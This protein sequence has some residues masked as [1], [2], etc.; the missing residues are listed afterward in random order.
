MHGTAQVITVKPGMPIMGTTV[1]DGGHVN[2]A[3]YQNAAQG[4]NTP[5]WITRASP[6]MRSPQCTMK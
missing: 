5:L 6:F 2:V 3:A 4:D 1:R